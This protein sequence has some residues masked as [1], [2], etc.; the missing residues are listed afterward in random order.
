MSEPTK[1]VVVLWDFSKES[2]YCLEHAIQLASVTGNSILFLHLIHE[3]S[4]FFGS[5]KL[6]ENEVLKI[7]AEIEVKAKEVNDKYNI[8]TNVI[9]K[10]GNFI[11]NLVSFISSDK[12]INLVVLPFHYHYTSTKCLKG[13]V[14][15]MVIKK[16]IVPYIVIKNPPHHKYYKEL[17]L[18]LDHDKKYK[19]TIAWIVFLA[20]YY[21]CNVNILKPYIKDEFMKKDMNNNVFFSKKILDKQNIVY[22]IKT[23]KKSQPF[24]DEIFRFAEL[25]DADIIVMMAKQYCK[26]IDNDDQTA[27]NAPILIVPPRVDIV[28]YGALA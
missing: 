16:T 1:T 18:P 6:N 8:V 11:K 9:V 24:K 23:A 10:T 15:N 3:K 7:K 5:A 14:F 26:W 25:I 28:K 22:G 12:R 13:K 17:V 19:E 2:E 21:R 27:L 4:G 20:H